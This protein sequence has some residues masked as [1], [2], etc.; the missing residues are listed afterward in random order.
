MTKD[1]SLQIVSSCG[2]Y[3]VHA[4]TKVGGKFELRQIYGPFSDK[5]AKNFKKMGRNKR[6]QFRKR[7][8][9]NRIKDGYCVD[10][11][12]KKP[13][14]QMTFDHYRGKKRFDI[15]SGSRVSWTKLS[16]EIEKCE[17]V[18]RSCHNIR[19]FLRGRTLLKKI[20]DLSELLSRYI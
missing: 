2:K 8:A 13:K 12:Q 20:E 6:R 1:E 7:M 11:N 16:E 10:C 17:L 9:I 5:E 3:Y 4:F 19:E 18:C 15:A 14:S